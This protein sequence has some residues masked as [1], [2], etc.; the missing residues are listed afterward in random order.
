ML[1]DGRWLPEVDQR[2][3]D[4]CPKM[5]GSGLGGSRWQ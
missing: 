2:V 4:G 3:V 1:D 5:H